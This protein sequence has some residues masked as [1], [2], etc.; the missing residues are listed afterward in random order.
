MTSVDALPT[1]FELTP[2]TT[3]L[4]IIDMQRDFL[5]P[6]GFG[7]SLGNDVSLLQKAIGPLRDLLEAARAAGILVVHTREGHLPDLSDCPPAK[8]QR[9]NPSHRIG[10]PGAFGRILIRGEYGHDIVD[11]L[12][13]V[14]GEIVIDKPGKGAFYA[15]ELQDVLTAAGVTRLLVT[16]VTTEVCVHTTVREAND[17]GYE[18]LVVSDCV[19]SYFPEFQRVGLDMISAQGGIF[20]WV[21]DSA[22][23]VPALA[24]ASTPA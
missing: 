9:G 20:G 15:T 13:P 6:G 7:E 10:D 11:E 17:R 3:A 12:A 14:E 4:V 24:L 18:C 2:E 23:V 21:A 16:G 8:L 19:G 5:L 1:P 22:A